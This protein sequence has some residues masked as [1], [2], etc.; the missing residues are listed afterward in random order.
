M[1]IDLLLVRL[2]LAKT[3]STAQ[4]QVAEAHIRLNGQRVTRKDQP[5]KPGD[6]LTMPCGPGVRVLEL[7]MLPERR[8]PPAEARACY[9]TL[10]AGPAIA[11]AEPKP[12]LE[13]GLW[14]HGAAERIE[15]KSLT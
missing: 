9:R 2:R 5:V 1:R 3:R 14:A 11:I 6:V 13:T 7:V 12:P 8:G 10:D 4:R 15:G